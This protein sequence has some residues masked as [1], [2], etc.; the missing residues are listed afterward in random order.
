MRSALKRPKFLILRL[1]EVYAREWVLA[2]MELV[3]VLNFRLLLRICIFL[4]YTQH[5][6]KNWPILQFSQAEDSISTTLSCIF[7]EL[8][9]IIS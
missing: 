5:I 4:S 8:F 1:K 6:I 2:L 3:E 7:D 9:F